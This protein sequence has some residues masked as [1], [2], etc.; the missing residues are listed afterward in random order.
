MVNLLG[1]KYIILK[2]P[3]IEDHLYGSFSYTKNTLG[4]GKIKLTSSG[5]NEE[6]N[7]FY[8]LKLKEFHPI[9]KL[10]KMTFKFVDYNNELYNF[11]GINHD[12][13]IAIH[14]YSAVQTN[15][16]NKSIINPEYNMNFIDYKYNK[17]LNNDDDDDE[18][19]YNI[20]KKK[21]E[22]YNR[23]IFDN[24]YD[25]NRETYNETSDNETSD[26]NIY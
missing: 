19:P 14:Y 16:L 8:K 7:T 10:S 25:V 9:G 13:I 24:G 23:S 4:L 21:E 26:N 3:E 12:M 20:Y 22:V 11:R 6:K 15:Y 1:T 17:P 2:S 18:V 5:L